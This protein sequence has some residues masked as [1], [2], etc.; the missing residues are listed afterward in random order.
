[1]TREPFL[2][3]T[4][5]LRTGLFA[6]HQRSPSPRRLL[7]RL[8][9]ASFAA[10]MA[11][12]IISV[13]ATDAGQRGVAIAMR[14][15]AVAALCVL[16]G[17]HLLRAVLHPHVTAA[18]I[19][20]PRAVFDAFSI[21][22]GVAV[23][24]VAMT[25][26]FSAAATVAIWLGVVAL[27][28]AALLLS[29]RAVFRHRRSW[30][31]RFVS[32][33]WL[34]AVVATESI[35]VLGTIA[36]AAA[37]N[38]VIAITTLVAWA[39]GLA[40]YPGVVVAIV[41]R[42]HSRGWRAADLTPDHWILMGA[43]AISTLGATSLLAA[44]N[45]GLLRIG[46]GSILVAA[47]VTWVAATALY[48]LLACLSVRGWLAA[49]GT[50]RR[51]GGWWALVFPLGMYSVCTFAFGH[52]ERSDVLLVLALAT[53]WVALAAWALVGATNLRVIAQ[54]VGWWRA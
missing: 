14:W 21:P 5:A 1:M 2:D 32:G 35:A 19:G 23:A 33:R 30:L 52:V 53:F 29:V 4:A 11:T 46:P 3:E 50:T 22:A 40:I 15:L 48:P 17:L 8:P 31:V 28:L 12:G 51:D 24:G 42:L 45:A 49:R 10:V 47:S 54:T 7:E 27:W 18:G 44:A 41:A 26:A 20:H 25:E 16:V 39:A 13:G 9:T 6:L 43:M 37:H 36:A 34:L 38:S